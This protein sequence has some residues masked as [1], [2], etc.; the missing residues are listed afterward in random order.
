MIVTFESIIGYVFYPFYGCTVAPESQTERTIATVI[1]ACIRV[2][3][4]VTDAVARLLR[5]SLVLTDLTQQIQRLRRG[6]GH[7]NVLA[8]T[9]GKRGVIYITA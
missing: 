8:D 2:T 7:S 5:T 6:A 3:L 9:A 4:S 1:I